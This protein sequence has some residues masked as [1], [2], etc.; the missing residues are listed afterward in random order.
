[1]TLTQARNTID[2]I[3]ARMHLGCG[4]HGCCI[5]APIGMGT[6]SVCRCTPREIARRLRWL[7]QELETQHTWT[8]PQEKDA[9][10]D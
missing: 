3:Q 6:N 5:Q 2:D 9:S 7:A 4:N 10:H 8:T 1:M